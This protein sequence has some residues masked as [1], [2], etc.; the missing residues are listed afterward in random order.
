MPGDDCL[1]S[2]EW[3]VFILSIPLL[4]LNFSA[5]ASVSTQEK[6]ASYSE[7][8]FEET[9][10]LQIFPINFGPGLFKR[11]VKRCEMFLWSIV[12]KE[13]K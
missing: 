11:D 1:D 8:E 9:T 7:L 13:K 6:L 5:N 12:K 3:A 2:W 10:F 4:E